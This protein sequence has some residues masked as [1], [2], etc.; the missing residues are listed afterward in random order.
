MPNGVVGQT[1]NG[2]LHPLSHLSESLSLSMLLKAERREVDTVT[3]DSGL[4]K[5]ADTTNTV[6]F[7]LHIR[8]TIGVAKVGQVRSP[9][10][11]FC[12][13]F[14]DHGILVESIGKRKGSL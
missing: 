14:H 8:V 1:D 4:G 5:N 9:G 7:H 6:D 13:T 3:E 12:I 11:V 2:E 10:C